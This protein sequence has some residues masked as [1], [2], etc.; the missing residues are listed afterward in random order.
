[1][2]VRSLAYAALGRGRA[3]LGGRPAPS[4][5]A[6][7]P[8]L[9]ARGLTREALR[10]AVPRLHDHLA[11]LPQSG[12]LC[13]QEETGSASTA[14]DCPPAII[15]LAGIPVVFNEQMQRDVRSDIRKSHVRLLPSRVLR[16]LT[17][18]IV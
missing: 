7:L 17:C 4:A 15:R 6:R 10:H 12:S 14:G 2:A 9:P 5:A 18:F 3:T 8:P 16:M 1:M 13:A 11:A